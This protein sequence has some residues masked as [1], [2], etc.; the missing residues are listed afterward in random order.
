VA[1]VVQ[2]LE[3]EAAGHRPVTDDRHDVA[4]ID[5]AG[6]AGHREAIG[7]GQH[8][9]GVAVFDDVVVALFAAR[10]AREA[11]RLTQFREAITAPGQDLVDVGLVAGVP[12]DCV[13]RRFEHSVQGDREFDHPEV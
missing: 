12:Q 9:R 11:S 8:G 2:R 5:G 13:A 4:P 7:I 10:I 1:E 6:V 3:G